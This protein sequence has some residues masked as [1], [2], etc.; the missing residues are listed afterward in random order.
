MSLTVAPF[1]FYNMLRRR[2]LHMLHCITRPYCGE[3]DF[4]KLNYATFLGTLHG[5]I[6]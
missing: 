3:A 2:T 6:L 5:F 1:H 4:R